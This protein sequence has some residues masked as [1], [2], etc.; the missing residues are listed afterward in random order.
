MGRPLPHDE[1]HA[2]D[3]GDCHVRMARVYRGPCAGE[4]SLPEDD[5]VSEKSSS[6]SLEFNGG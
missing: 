6:L 5:P 2:G 1:L 3:G 4:T